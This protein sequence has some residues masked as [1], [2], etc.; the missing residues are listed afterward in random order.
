MEPNFKQINIENI[1]Y[2]QQ[3]INFLLFLIL[4][5]KANICFII[6]KLIRFISN[7]NNIY[8]LIIKQIFRYLKD[9]VYLNIV[10]NKD[11]PNYIQE[12]ANTDYIDDQLE[13]KS[14]IRYLLFITGDI[15]IWKFKL[16]FII[17][18]NITEIEMVTINIYGKKLIFI[19]ILLIELDFF[20]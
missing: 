16:Q 9:T 10:Y 11:N 20:R 12:Y 13:A 2:Y 5:I 14:T 3:L 4:I 7:F 19:K 15:F 8:F 1:N 6:I 17:V 18:Q